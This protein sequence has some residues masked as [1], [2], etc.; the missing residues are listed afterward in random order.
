MNEKTQDVSAE[1]EKAKAQTEASAVD[2]RAAKP[3]DAELGQRHPSDYRTHEERERDAQLTEERGD[4]VRRTHP[5]A[6][7]QHDKVDALAQKRN[8]EN[9]PGHELNMQRIETEAD[10][11]NARTEHAHDPRANHRPTGK[12]QNRNTPVIDPKTGE[13][14]W[15]D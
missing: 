2:A 7:A 5:D 9:R 4:P 11:A 14:R 13:K 1:T 8:E 10:E 6:Q 12:Q 15:V 3:S